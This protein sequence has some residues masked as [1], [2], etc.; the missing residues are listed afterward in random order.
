MAKKLFSLKPPSKHQYSPIQAPILANP[1]APICHKR[2]SVTSADPP[3]TP[4]HHKRWSATSINPPQVSIHSLCLYWCVRVWVCLVL[5]RLWLILLLIL[6]LN[7]YFC[8]LFFILCLWECVYQRKK[9]IMGERR[10]I[11]FSDGEERE[12]KKK[13]NWKLL[14]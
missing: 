6:W 11:D 14:K 7:F 13:R 10:C 8:G 2:R 4:I 1:Q 3:Q 9:K 5:W 12:K